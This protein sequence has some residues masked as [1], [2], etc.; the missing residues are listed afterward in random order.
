MGGREQAGPPGPRLWCPNGC[1]NWVEKIGVPEPQ[2]AVVVLLG[3]EPFW[4]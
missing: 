2:G 3:T 4:F 1:D